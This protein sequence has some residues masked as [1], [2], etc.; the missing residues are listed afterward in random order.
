M[1]HCTG[2]VIRCR[3]AGD[4]STYISHPQQLSNSVS[5]V[6]RQLDL[7]QTSHPGLPC[8]VSPCAKHVVQAVCPPQVL[9]PRYRQQLSRG[10]SAVHWTRFTPISANRSMFCPVIR[11]S[12]TTS[13]YFVRHIESVIRISL[14]LKFLLIPATVNY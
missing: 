9:P 13:S 3:L 2:C 8:L 1:F 6:C 7:D 5:P 11:L 4:L 10:R 12:F 14:A